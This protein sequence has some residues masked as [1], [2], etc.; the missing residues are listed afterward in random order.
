[1]L[2]WQ[3]MVRCPLLLAQICGSWRRP[4][5]MSAFGLKSNTRLLPLYRLQVLLSGVVAMHA[6]G[7]VL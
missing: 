5:C 4:S 6:A 2:V 3:D 1:M 7:H